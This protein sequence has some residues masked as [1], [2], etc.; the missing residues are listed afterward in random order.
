VFLGNP[1]QGECD[2]TVAWHIDK[3][4]FDNTSLQGLN[5]VAVFHTPGNMWTSPKWK[6]ALYIDEIATKEQA[7]ALGKI[8]SGKAGGFFGVIAGF[9]GELAGVRS[10]PIKFEKNGKRRT[11]QIPSAIDITIEGIE[12]ADKT[13]EVT[14]DNAPMHVAPGLPAVVAKSTKNSY[15]DHGMKWD[16]SGKKGC[17]SRFAYTP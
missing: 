8:Y 6:A 4:Q 2:V 5:V 1:D 13:K 15:S 7:D 17:Y 16:N 12:G 9:V 11:L 3:G 10:M 14:V